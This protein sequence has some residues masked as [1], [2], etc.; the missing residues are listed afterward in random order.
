MLFAVKK[1]KDSPVKD[2]RGQKIKDPIS[3][4]YITN[5]ELIDE[6]IDVE[7]IKAIRPIHV[8]GKKHKDVD[9]PITVIYLYNSKDKKDTS[10]IHVIGDWED[11]L[12]QVNELKSG[13]GNRQTKEA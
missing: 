2:E 9:D 11:I 10:E 6:A 3:D 8:S 12:K 4:Q 13:V 1:I 7:S 5:E